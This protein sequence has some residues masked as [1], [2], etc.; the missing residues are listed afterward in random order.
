MKRLTKAKRDPA[1]IRQRRGV[2]QTLAVQ[3]AIYAAPLVATYNLRCTVAV[4]PNPKAPPGQ[5]WRLVEIT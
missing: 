4:G 1:V 5:F 3:S 2:A